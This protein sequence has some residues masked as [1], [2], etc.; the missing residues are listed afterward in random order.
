MNQFFT[1]LPPK[2]QTPDINYASKV[3]LMGS[4][5][6]ENIGQRLEY[7]KFQTKVNPFGIIFHPVALNNLIKR[8]I[9]QRLFTEKDIIYQNEQW[10]CFE[11]HSKL[12]N[13]DKSE[14]VS[15]LNKQ[16]ID[17]YNWITTASHI[18]LTY[19]TAWGY[20]RNHTIVANC[21]KIPQKEFTK[22]I[23]PIDQLENDITESVNLLK[24]L[25]PTAAVLFTVSPVRHLK[26]GIVANNQSKAHLLSAIHSVIN[27]NADTHYYP[28]YELV[29]DC[30]RDYRFYTPDLLHPNETAIDFIWE[31]F[32][33]TYM[34]DDD[35]KKTIKQVI[36]IQRGLQHKAFNPKSEAHKK[37]MASLHAKITR[38]TRDF[39]FMKF[40]QIP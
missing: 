35:T 9:E 31:H 13:P 6:V 17:T 34:H 21:H 32:T 10:H 12:S 26:D 8:V 40:Y 19:G 5:F 30:L 7:H 37:F 33:A 25:N 2:K 15:L 11:V 28:A 1:T 38:I 16:I 23:T 39:P 3:L 24:K 29:V 18:V 27:K 14:F 20:T 4:C 22:T 36:E